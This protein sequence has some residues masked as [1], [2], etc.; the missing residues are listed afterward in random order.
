MGFLGGG[1][2]GGGGQIHKK[3]FS[4][5]VLTRI[6]GPES[7]FLRLVTTKNKFYAREI[8]YLISFQKSADLIIETI[9]G[10]FHHIQPGQENGKVGNCFAQFVLQ[11]IML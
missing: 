1:G 7:T 3:I 11:I 6:S 2:G 9:S 8:N 10:C 5:V 4:F